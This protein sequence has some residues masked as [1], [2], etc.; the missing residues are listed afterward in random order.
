MN[1]HSADARPRSGALALAALAV[2]LLISFSAAAT[3]YF[4]P[5]GEW[6]ASLERPFFAPPNWIF[7]P[8]WTVLYIFIA[9]AGWLVWRRVGLAHA[10]IGW[11]ALQMVLNAGWTPLFFGLQAL[12]LAL[13]EMALLWAAILICVR[14][15]RP[16]S[17]TASWLMLPYLAW[18][19]FAWV[20]NA[21]FWWLN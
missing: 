16:I 6:Y 15:F 14:Q 21:G 4:F 19:T 18:V 17:K 7:G 1:H 8:V 12:G 5:P 20:L 9:V 10:A 11:W 2:F 13:V 3:G